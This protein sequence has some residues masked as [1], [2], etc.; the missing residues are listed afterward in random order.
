MTLAEALDQS[1]SF[2]ALGNTQS[3]CILVSANA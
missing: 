2:T 1:V 3:K